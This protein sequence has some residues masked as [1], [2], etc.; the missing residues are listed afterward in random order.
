MNKSNLTSTNRTIM[1]NPRP[2]GNAGGVKN[3]HLRAFKYNYVLIQRVSLT[4]N[5]TL[6]TFRL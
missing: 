3:M 4:A 2:T 5:C 6:R 1:L